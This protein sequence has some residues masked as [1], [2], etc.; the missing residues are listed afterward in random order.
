ME[1]FV[2]EFVTVSQAAKMK[3]YSTGYVRQLCIDGK[4]PGAQKM[5][6]QWIIPKKSIIDYEPKKKGFAAVW[7]RKR[8]Y[9]KAEDDTIALIIKNVVQSGGILPSETAV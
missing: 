3:K 6:N 2:E 7:E 9:Q 4:L 1:E 5:G 8:A